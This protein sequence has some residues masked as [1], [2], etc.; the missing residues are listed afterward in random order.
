MA[1]TAFSENICSAILIEFAR[2]SG[3]SRIGWTFLNR[4]AWSFSGPKWEF[5]GFLSTQYLQ[6][7]DP[8]LIDS[9][10]G[11][12]ALFTVDGAIIRLLICTEYPKIPLTADLV[13]VWCDRPL[14]LW[15]VF[16][17]K[18]YTPY[19]YFW[20]VSPSLLIQSNQHAINR[21]DQYVLQYFQMV[22]I[23]N[24]N[25]V[26]KTLEQNQIYVV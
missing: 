10:T 3:T 5:A 16:H 2:L 6:G 25:R 7:S 18:R 17:P 21:G 11:G 12:C 14:N 26:Y 20:H 23:S 15:F 9:H 8:K 19:Q 1:N 13:K 24:Y 4:R 22:L